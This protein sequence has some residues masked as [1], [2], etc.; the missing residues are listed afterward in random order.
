MC[1]CLRT[2]STKTYPFSLQWHIT[3]KCDQ[4]CKHCYMYDSPFYSSERKNELSLEQCKQV[5]DDL[6]DTL[7]HW[8]KMGSSL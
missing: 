7:K 2:S 5:V 1:T 8:K 4:T 6:S 3:A